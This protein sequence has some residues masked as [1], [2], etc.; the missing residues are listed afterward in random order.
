MEVDV[1]EVH[2]EV[3]P[4]QPINLKAL[5]AVNDPDLEIRQLLA[6]RAE[7]GELEPAWQGS[8]LEQAIPGQLLLDSRADSRDRCSCVEN[9]RHP[10]ST[11]NVKGDGDPSAGPMELSPDCDLTSC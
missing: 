9:G 3:Q 4:Q 5:Q 10:V 8:R 6:L 2:Q 11:I 1:L 7:T